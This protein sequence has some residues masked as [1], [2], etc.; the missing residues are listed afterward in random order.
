MKKIIF[1]LMLT[2]SLNAYCLSP[3][4]VGFGSTTRNYATA[5]KDDSGKSEKFKFN[6][7]LLLGTTLPFFFA[8]FYFVPGIGYAI[9][10][11]EDNTSRKE[12]ILQYHIHQS[13]NSFFLLKYGLSN[14]IVKIGGKGGTVQLNNGNSTS[15][16][17][18]PSESKT[19]YIASLDFGGE[20]I[21][22]SNIGSR[23]QVSVD[24]FLSSE[25]RRVSHILTLNYYY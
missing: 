10:S 15:T 7:T 9:Y 20:L 8:D 11:S 13:I 18:T 22:T 16:F 6:P 24:R 19:S 14:T 25:R 2:F 5:Q 4:W 12:I 1:T 17:Y 23:L 3:L 21:F